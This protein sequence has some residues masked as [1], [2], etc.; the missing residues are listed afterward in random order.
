M[1][2]ANHMFSDKIIQNIHFRYIFRK[3]SYKAEWEKE[4][5]WVQP[6]KNDKHQAECKLCK[7]RFQ[8]CGSGKG[9]GK[10]HAKGNRHTE[11]EKLHDSN[12]KLVIAA[13]ASDEP[14]SST[15]VS[16][17]PRPC[18]FNQMDKVLKAEI[19]AA[20][21]YVKFHHSFKSSNQDGDLYAEMF[22][23]SEIAK[24]YSMGKTKLKYLIQF[25]IAPYV[26]EI[27][28]YE[29]K[30]SA[31]SFSFDETTTVQKKKQLDGYVSYVDK[32][33]DN[34][35]GVYIGSQFLDHGASGDIIKS[36]CALIEDVALD[37]KH[38]ISIGMD[39]PNV[40]KKFYEMIKQK[41]QDDFNTGII[42]K[43]SC[44]LHT[45]NNGFRAGVKE[46]KFDIELFVGDLVFFFEMSTT[47]R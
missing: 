15:S 9:Q 47:R 24:L 1:F 41:V 7:T 2:L 20:L 45:T 8:I 11:L 35:N 29:M 12:R 30:G 27:I 26:K 4:Y 39:G 28:M 40:N 33:R 16:L 5:K 23:D 36:V 19:L 18:V 13:S 3:C 43:G 25:G 31:F 22:P 42:D 6:V 44:M 34:V 17:N 46:F 21:K 38:L 32:N 37:F 10:A 14:A